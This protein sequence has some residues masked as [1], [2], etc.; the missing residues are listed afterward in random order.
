MTAALGE[1]LPPNMMINVT[2]AANNKGTIMEDR[3]GH[4]IDPPIM[5]TGEV[6]TE[7]IMMGHTFIK[8][9]SYI[10]ELALKMRKKR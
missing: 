6:A 10:P 1:N 8:R 5:K 2:Q 3:Q 4:T 9:D 7:I